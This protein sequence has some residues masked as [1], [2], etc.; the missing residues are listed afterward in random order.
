MKI[1]FC[2]IVKGSDDE[3]LLLNN[4][5]GSVKDYVD[6]IFITITQPN[7]AVRAT[8]LRYGA[9]VS[10]FEWTGDFS[11]A[12]NFNFAQVPK[13]YDFIMW[14]DADDT[15]EGMEHLRKSLETPADAYL[16]W[17]VYDHDSYGMPNVVHAK[18]MVVKNDGSFTWRGRIHEDLDSGREVSVFM[19]EDVKRIHH[20]TKERVEQSAQRNYGIAMTEDE[21][22][23]RTWWNRSNALL[24]LAKYDKAL[25]ALHRF[26]EVSGSEAE[27]YL[28]YIRMGRVAVEGKRYTDAV[29]CAKKAIAIHYDWPDAYFALGEFLMKLKSYY[30]ARDAIME[31]LRKKPPVYSMVVYNPRDYDYNPLMLLANCYWEMGRPTLALEALKGCLAIQPKNEN[32]K[33]MVETVQVDADQYEIALKV[34][35]K[36]NK[37]KSLKTAKKLIDGLPEEIRKHPIVMQWANQHF[38]RTESSGKDVVYFCGITLEKWNPDSI[39]TGIGGSEEAVILLS[40]E[41]AKQGY[42]VTVYANCG[43]EKVYDGVLWRPWWLYN[44]RDKQDITVFWRHLRSLDHDINSTKVYVDLHDTISPAEFTEVRVAKID[45]VFVKSQAHRALYPTVPDDKFAIINNPIDTSLFDGEVERDQ[46]LIVNTSSPERSLEAV[47]RI[48]RKIK[49]KEPRAKMKWAYGWNVYD[50]VRSTE[51]Q[52]MRWKN[53]I[54]EY[55]EVVGIEELGRISHKEVAR[56]YKSAQVFLYPTR[57]YEIDCISARKAQIA[58][59]NVVSSDFAAL[60]ET[61]EIGTKIH[62]EPPTVTNQE[63]SDIEE[64]DEQYVNAVLEAFTKQPVKLDPTPHTP[65][66]IAKRWTDIWVS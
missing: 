45:R 44:P 38:V 37:Y 20:P 22:D 58:G 63:L 64:N 54:R 27:K 60:N 23:P 7:D 34:R 19:V 26:V 35:E 4:L 59:A 33:K 51:E 6:G 32:L 55:M 42:N 62:A 61:V 1:A 11:K 12:R 17:Y 41:W 49:E 5:L 66:A 31:G 30:D 24:S 48:F 39:K 8:A 53:A 43:E 47:C 65:Q 9:T 25:D 10:D 2:A 16:M 50:M 13:D 52:A 36:L 15:Y 40:R 56:L 21:S 29:A 28:A 57:F 18:T 14:G 3:A 46:F